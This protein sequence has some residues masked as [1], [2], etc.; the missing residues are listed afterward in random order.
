L[1]LSLIYSHY[2]KNSL[3][4][5]DIRGTHREIFF[6]FEYP[7]ESDYDYILRAGLSKKISGLI[8]TSIF[9]NINGSENYF[10]GAD[11]GFDLLD[12]LRIGIEGDYIY[13][14]KNKDGFDISGYVFIA[15]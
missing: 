15:F 12:N 6:E 8:N 10:I 4:Y 9:G 14:W 13:G 1:P 11:F 2:L 3:N 5:L 7:L